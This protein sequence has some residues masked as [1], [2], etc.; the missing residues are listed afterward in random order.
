MGLFVTG[1][2]WAQD[3]QYMFLQA[4]KLQLSDADT[5]VTANGTTLSGDYDDLPF[6]TG[7]VQKI[8]GGSDR[9][10]YGYEGGAVISWQNDSVSYS[11]VVNGGATVN[12]KVENEMFLFGTMLGGYGDI[13]FGDRARL[14]LS[15]GPMLLMASLK[16][17]QEKPYPQPLSSAVVINGD[18]RDFSFGY[19]AYASL[20][21]IFSVG[22]KSEFGLVVREQAVEM[23]FNDA[24]ADFPYDGTQYM[25]S[26]GY[27]M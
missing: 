10:R 25:L 24:I 4:G 9:V 7:G 2:C 13:N 1:L 17:D 18:E 23:D 12:I 5:T 22:G 21:L 19:G 8:L 26:F 6:F 27:R 3:T 15:G 20:G 11:G 16:Q 14:F